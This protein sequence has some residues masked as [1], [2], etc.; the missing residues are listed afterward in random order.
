MADDENR[1][2]G[3]RVIGAVMMQF[4]AA[5]RAS[6][7]DLQVAAEDPP[8]PQAGQRPMKPRRI[9]SQISRFGGASAC[10]AKAGKFSAGVAIGASSLD[11]CSLQSTYP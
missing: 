5:V 10:G 1:H 6:G 4:L 2:V 11:R 9:E 3:R 7:V 8:S